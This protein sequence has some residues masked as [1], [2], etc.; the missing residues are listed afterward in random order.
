MAQNFGEFD[1][2]SALIKKYI[3]AKLFSSQTLYFKVDNDK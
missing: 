1:F 2:K 3:L